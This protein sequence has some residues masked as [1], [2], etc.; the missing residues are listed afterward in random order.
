MKK[1]LIVLFSMLWVL[2]GYSN[3]IL[4]NW[5]IIKVVEQGDSL[6]VN[7]EYELRLRKIVNR[8]DEDKIGISISDII[9]IIPKTISEYQLFIKYPEKYKQEERAF[10]RLDFEI[11]DRARNG[12]YDVLV[13]YLGMIEYID[14]NDSYGIDYFESLGDEVIVNNQEKFCRIYPNLNIKCKLLLIEY[15]AFCNK[16]NNSRSKNE[17]NTSVITRID[18]K[19]TL[20]K[21]IKSFS[22]NNKISDNQVVNIIPKSEEEY[23]LFC[24]FPDKYKEYETSFYQFEREMINRA[25]EGNDAIFEYYIRMGEF[26]DGYYSE[27]FLNN[28]DSVIKKNKEKFCN[29]Y[30]TLNDRCSKLLNIYELICLEKE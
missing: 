23:S 9:S 28:V 30:Y 8:F 18:Y 7:G 26:V 25:R 17:E 6:K 16:H 12:D 11:F 15:N 14:K 3:T 5:S 24:Q 20:E 2:E 21:T 29:I 10:G 27:D 4:N 13:L 22:L 1:I 19:I